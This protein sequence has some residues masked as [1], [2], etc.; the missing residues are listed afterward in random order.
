VTSATL[1]GRDCTFEPHGRP[2]IFRINST[3]ARTFWLA[4]GFGTGGLHDAASAESY[5]PSAARTQALALS[6]DGRYLA[7]T[8]TPGG[9]QLWDLVE[10]EP[11]CANWGWIGGMGR[12]QRN[13]REE[14]F[15]QPDSKGGQSPDF[16][17]TQWSLVRRASGPGS[18][19]SRE[20]RKPFAGL[21]G[22]PFMPR[23]P[24]G[25]SPS[26]AQDLTQEFFARLLASHSIAAPNPRLGK[27]RTS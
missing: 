9:V 23:S 26:D 15:K 8:W 12:L 11:G 2:K 19:E 27:F 21:I 20:A 3:D 13:E 1:A 6:P 22:F 17:R 5:S 10:V 16:R 14:T 24:A 4:A 25:Q 18:P 7:A